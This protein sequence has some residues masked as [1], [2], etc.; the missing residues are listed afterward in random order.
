VRCIARWRQKTSVFLSSILTIRTLG[1]LFCHNATTCRVV[2]GSK[3]TK[4]LACPAY[5]KGTKNHVKSS[6]FRVCIR[7]TRH[8]TTSTIALTSLEASNNFRNPFPTLLSYTIPSR[9]I[10]QSCSSESREQ[11]HIHII[12]I[13]KISQGGL[14]TDWVLMS[15]LQ[16]LYPQIFQL[17][18]GP[19]AKSVS[20]S[21][22][23]H[24]SFILDMRVFSP[25]QN[26]F[27]CYPIE[28]APA[29]DCLC[30]TVSV[31]VRWY[32]GESM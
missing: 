29:K 15:P 10:S 32:L 18:K 13:F 22:P 8:R 12:V 25:N 11:V 14:L 30:R 7:R 17:P 9:K 16:P 4:R 19:V 31:W 6:L 3:P 27:R 28:Y 1:S 26:L 20:F 2:I 23:G 5:K 24:E 21:F